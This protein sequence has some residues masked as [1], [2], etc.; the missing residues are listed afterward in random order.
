MKN[1]ISKSGNHKRPFAV[2]HP[3]NDAQEK[4]AHKAMKI[5]HPDV[6]PLLMTK[7]KEILN[8]GQKIDMNQIYQ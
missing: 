2:M 6:N 4:T 5:E 3:N 8:P 7:Q 1:P